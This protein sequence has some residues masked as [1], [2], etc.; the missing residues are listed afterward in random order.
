MNINS[1]TS[2][3][4][5]WTNTLRTLTTEANTKTGIGSAT[6]SVGAGLI[7][8]LRPA[9]GVF[10]IVVGN[11][12]FQNNIDTGIYDG[13]TF[14]AV[15]IQSNP[16]TIPCGSAVGAAIKNSTAGALNASYSGFDMA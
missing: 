5:V 13:A 1:T 4:S 16:V 2:P 14:S 7:L 11:T 9:A 8:D 12:A 3:T 10:R 15:A 6:V